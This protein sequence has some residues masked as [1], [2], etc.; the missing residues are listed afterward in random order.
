MTR[1]S[2][3]HRWRS[4]AVLCLA[5]AGAACSRPAP[6][7]QAPPA[8]A[9]PTHPV[10]AEGLATV[11]GMAPAGAVV[12]LEPAGGALPAPSAPAVMD[13][14]GKQFL[15]GFLM[16]QQGQ[17]VTFLNGEDIPHNIF[18]VQRRVGRTILD[19]STD[20]GQQYAHVFERPGEFDVSCNI[21]PGME[22]VIIVTASPFA[23]VAD[24]KG[25][26]AIPNVTPGTYTLIVSDQG[27]P[28]ESSVAVAAPL[29]EIGA[30]SR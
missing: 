23:A 9:G 19:V 14:R 6:S 12:S 22:A 17:T 30:T 26:F 10:S 20:P 18:V 7:A 1:T 15:P 27:S 5:V 25:R 2:Y 28:T 11:V 3:P 29:T 4:A 21:H 24:G 8:A 13:Q 16:A